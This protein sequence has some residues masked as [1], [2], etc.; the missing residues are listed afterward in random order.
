MS[1]SSLSRVGAALV[2]LS[3]LGAGAC[4]APSADEAGSSTAAQSSDG[5]VD[6]AIDAAADAAP[7][8]CPAPSGTF[9]EA[10]FEQEV[11]QWKTSFIAS[12]CT[13]ADIDSAKAAL[14]SGSATFA[15]LK[16]ALGSTCSACAFGRATDAS[17]KP[18]VEVGGGAIIN[19]GGCFAAYTNSKA[20][21]KGITLGE[22]C[23]GEVCAEAD[24]GSEQA[25][26]RCAQIANQAGGDCHPF[27]TDQAA[28]GTDD[29]VNDV[30]GSLLSNIAFV[31][32]GGADGGLDASTP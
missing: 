9:S 27:A 17:W 11:G 12:A 20:C 19:W 16:A 5:G 13:Q 25:R 15:S 8:V 2:S 14:A 18:I 31:C 7:G 26:R 28:C 23:H 30:C 24:C 10:R 22:V 1:P 32:G 3:L 21:G 4:A 29:A 6:A